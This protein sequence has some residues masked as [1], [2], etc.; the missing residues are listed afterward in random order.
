MKSKL[1]ERFCS[2]YF[3]PSLPGHRIKGNLLY[4]ADVDYLLRGYSFESSAF[5]KNRFTIE[6]FIQPLYMPVDYLFFNFGNRLGTL[7][8]ESDFWWEYDETKEN[9]MTSD[10]LSMIKKFGEKFLDKGRSLQSF[11]NEFDK[12]DI[13]R[14]PN[15]KEAVG[16]AY[17]L[18]EE[19][20]RPKVLMN[21][22]HHSLVE[23][24]NKNPEIDWLTHM[25]NRVLTLLDLLNKGEFRKAKQQLLDWR[26][27]TLSKLKLTGN[28]IKN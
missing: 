7:S 26:E 16:N 17:I 28:I 19:Y 15:N 21:G 14:N 1:V 20:R 25:D 11:V 24:I 23:Q 3:V 9:E 4:I 6:V 22:L 8:K 2:K 10:I 5:S 18:L 27:Y 12:P 13:L